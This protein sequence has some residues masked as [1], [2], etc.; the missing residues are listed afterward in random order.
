MYLVSTTTRADRIIKK[1]KSDV[2]QKF[3]IVV[4]KLRKDPFE[5]TLKT[6]QL[7]GKLKGSWSCRLD[8][9]DRVLFVLIEADKEVT[10]FDIGSHDEVY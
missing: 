9:A 10:I 7:G 5:S 4:E 6:H 2:R 3:D 1:M 8:Y